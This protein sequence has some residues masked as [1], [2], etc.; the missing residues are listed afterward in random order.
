VTLGLTVLG[1]LGTWNMN[2]IG[3]R[4]QKLYLYHGLCVTNTFFS[5]KPR[6]RVSWRHPRSGIWHSL[7]GGKVLL[8]PKQM[9]CHI[10]KGRHY[11]NAARTSIPALCK[12]SVML[13]PLSRCSKSVPRLMHIRNE[14]LSVSRYIT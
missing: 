12:L 5:T 8:Q 10:Q 2:E 6:H 13:S 14:Y 9:R 4:L 7:V 1:N 11:V 3:Q